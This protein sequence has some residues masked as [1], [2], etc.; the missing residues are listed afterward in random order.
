MLSHN[1][2]ETKPHEA[3]DGSESLYMQLE[4]R[5]KQLEAKTEKELKSGSVSSNGTPWRSVN[6]VHTKHERVGASSRDRLFLLR[7]VLRE[8]SAAGAPYIASRDGMIQDFRGTQQLAESLST[9]K[10]RRVPATPRQWRH[11]RGALHHHIV[12]VSI[13]RGSIPLHLADH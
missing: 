2:I 5:L 3:D 6:T 13:D 12:M 1:A 7:Q 9:V 11:P 8:L 4:E 10:S